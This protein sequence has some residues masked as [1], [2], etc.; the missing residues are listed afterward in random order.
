MSPAQTTSLPPDRGHV[1]TEQRNPRTMSIDACT[2]EECVKL[3]NDEDATIASAVRSASPAITSFIEDLEPRYR[4]GG[5]LIYIGAGT[6]GRLGVLDASECPPTFQTEPDRVV[7]IIAGGDSALRT[8]S[9]SKEDHHDAS[10]EELSVLDLTP[11]DTLLG[12]AAGGT[13]P[14]VLGAIEHAR[15]CGALTGL[16]TCS[17]AA[18]TIDVDHM[19][20]I[21]TGPEPITG[22]TRMKAG[23]ATK[24]VLNTISTTLMIRVGKVYQNLMVDLRATNDKLRDR[25]LRILMELTSL[26]RSDAAVLLDRADGQLKPAIV[27]H[28]TSRTFDDAIA[29]LARH[30]GVLRDALADTGA[31]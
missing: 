13:T 17:R 1:C 10:L 24:L 15:S 4:R 23:T 28:L 19:L 20:L 25:A 16:L 22:S 2:I 3:L 7:G 9:E 6:S 11:N 31:P 26:D 30:D 14:Y 29:S 21:D 8:S 18:T 5:R 27:M 12:I